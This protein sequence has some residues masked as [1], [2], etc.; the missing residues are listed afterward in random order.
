MHRLFLGAMVL[1]SAVTLVGIGLAQTPGG[2]AAQFRDL[3]LQLDAN[4]DG[5]LAKD[6]VPPSAQPAFERLLK[7]GD[8]NHNG[9]LEAD[10][11]RTVLLDLRDFA[12]RTKEQAARKFQS[13]D[14]DGDSKVSR[15]EFTGPKPR[16][17][18]LDR[19]GDGFLTREEFLGGA[20]GKAAAKAKAAAKKKAA[21][22][23][24]PE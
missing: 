21:A 5:A 23:K 22:V 10:E 8:A 19:N 13:M 20:L 12:E 24:K 11:Y 17:D 1:L 14:K 6:E 7:R 18:V 4:Q 16:F 2:P 9:K 3:F 15:D